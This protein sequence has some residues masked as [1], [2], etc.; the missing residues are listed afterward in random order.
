RG[1]LLPMME[2]NSWLT[3]RRGVA[4]PFTDDCEPLCHNES[5]FQKLFEAAADF[6]V[7]HGWKHLELRGG[8]QF[9]AGATPSLSFFGHRLDLTAGES[10]L[11]SRFDSATRRAIRKAEKEGVTVEITH[12]FDSLLSFYELQCLTRRRHGLPPQPFAFFRNLHQ[13]VLSRNAG[14]IALAHYQKKPVAGAVFF[15][16]GPRA[17]FKFGASDE[18]FQHLRGNNLA[19]WEAIKTLARHGLRQLDFGKTAE[20]HDGL[21]RFKLGWGATEHRIEYFKFNLNRRAFV[22]DRDQAFGWHNRIFQSLP[23]P[24]SRLIGSVLYRHW[25]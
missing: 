17:V 23:L 3:G 21:R 8:R 24:A 7:Q 22:A 16:H 11:F 13:H 18:S 25:A 4:L 2:I 12:R 19:M 6:G 5:S 9:L 1:N 15:F 14:F 10:E 20:A